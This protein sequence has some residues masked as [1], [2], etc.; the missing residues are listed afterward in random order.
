MRGTREFALYLEETADLLSLKD[1]NFFRIRA[2]RDA[3]NTL[4]HTEEELSRIAEGEDGR[5]FEGIGAGMI[6]KIREYLSTGDFREH[7]ELLEKVPRGVLEIMRIPKL[8]PKK[9]RVL[10]EK[11]GITSV[12]EL[13]KS[14]ESGRLDSL[15]GFGDKTVSNILEGIKQLE[16]YSARI[17]ISEADEIASAV[18]ERLRGIRGVKKAQAAGSLRRRK[19]TEGDIDILYTGK[20][21]AREIHED[22]IKGLKK[23]EV[24][25]LGEKK[26]SFIWEGSCQVDLRYIEEDEWGAALQYFTGSKE[27][28]VALR[29][30]AV[31]KGLKVSEYGVFR[32]GRKIAGKTEE[33]VYNSLG[34]QYIHPEL[35]ENM[36]ELAAAA[37]EELPELVAP[38]DI[39]GDT[40]VHSLYSDGTDSIEEI[41]RAAKDIGYEWIAICDHSVSLVIA[42]GLDEKRLMEKKKEIERV[43]ANIRG[44]D[45]LCGQEV[46]IRKDGTLDYPDDVLEKLDF[47][48][49]AVHTGFTDPE[50]IITGRI[51]KAMSSPYV[52]AVAHLTGRLINE[53]EPYAVDVPRIIDEAARTGTAL[54]INA[55]PQ[56]LDLYYYYAKLAREKGVRL[57]IGTD[58]HHRGDLGAMKY[59]V[60]VARRGWLEK[61]DV[62]NTM[63][64]GALRKFLAK[65][66]AGL[67]EKA[68]GRA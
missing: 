12:E 33:E 13:R 4:M 64:A 15:A 35:R 38:G 50:D 53:R 5:H 57:A 1:G 11:L 6:S 14:I 48:I 37:A 43:R 24:I 45:I 28:N 26:A 9:T 18:L 42:N 66:R 56:R 58:S 68:G 25:S 17:L 10:F 52:T 22:F 46:D 51:I 27:H 47:V 3:A 63:G 32:G 55:N 54:E 34:M 20:R 2:Y 39:K 8:G 16:I 23:K 44:I 36:G 21:P 7:S 29:K 19:E 67:K 49:A 60:S 30:H 62:I 65:K 41:A 31:R 61:K 59:G 40:H